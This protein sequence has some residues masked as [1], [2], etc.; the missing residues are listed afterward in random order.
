MRNGEYL[1]D[2]T[3]RVRV[4]QVHRGNKDFH[5]ATIETIENNGALGKPHEKRSEIES[6]SWIVQKAWDADQVQ[7]FFFM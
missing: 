1:V 6:R 4:A 3:G 7:S 2:E 5:K